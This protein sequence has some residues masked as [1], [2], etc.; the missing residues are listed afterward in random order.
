MTMSG[1]LTLPRQ[2]RRLHRRVRISVP[3]ELGDQAPARATDLS[4]GGI[5]LL[6]ELPPELG[7][8]VRVRA[9]FADGTELDTDGE[10]TRVMGSHVAIRFTALEQRT[11]L[12]LLAQIR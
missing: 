2:E 11:L 8:R 1:A 7:S 12:A 3:V 10:V 5:G 4:L 9:R 6:C